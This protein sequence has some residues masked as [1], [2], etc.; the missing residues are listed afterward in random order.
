M[1]QRLDMEGEFREYV[2]HLG[3]ALGHAD[4]KSPLGE[5]MTGLLL[6]LERKSVEPMAAVMD[7]RR[8]GTAHQRMH[9]F[10]AKSGWRDEDLLK[11]VRTWAF[12]RITPHDAVKVWIIDDT[13]F[14]K[15][16]RQS[17]GVARQYCGQVGKQDNCQVA[18]SLSLAGE[19]ASLPVGYRLYLPR[20]WADDPRRRAQAEIP[21]EIG[22]QTKHE[23][24]LELIRKAREEGIP[25]AVVLADAGYGTDTEFREALSRMEM[26]YAVGIQKTTNVWTPGAAPLQPPAYSGRGRPRTLRIRDVGHAPVSV[27]EL[28][29]ALPSKAWRTI[30]WRE[31]VAGEMVSRFA[32][33]R[34]HAAHRD[35]GRETLR[36]QEWLVIEWPRGEAEPTK[37]VLSTMQADTKFTEMIRT[38]KMRWRIERDYHELKQEIG[39]GHFEGRGWIGFHHHAS[40]CIAAYAFLVCSRLAFSPSGLARVLFKVPAVPEGFR[41]RGSVAQRAARPV[42]P[43]DHPSPTRHCTVGAPVPLSLLSARVQGIGGYQWAFMTQSD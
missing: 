20:E 9:H 33:V 17:V 41:P 30:T 37:Y 25:H 18:V 22:F 13:G 14:P 12:P 28:A 32:R 6:P 5:Y 42:V 40:L 1:G 39:L 4:R 23:I 24:A 3:T 34:V 31:G 26:V 27:A 21:D 15:K 36:Q 38:I 11:A 7:P 16:G 10:V 2:E 8:T 43:H 35:E 19:R 29:A